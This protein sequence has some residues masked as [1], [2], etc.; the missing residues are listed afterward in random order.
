MLVVERLDAVIA[1]DINGSDVN[2]VAETA[3]PVAGGIQLA[4][5][6]ITKFE[7]TSETGQSQSDGESN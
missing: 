2:G 6:Y 4:S 3:V 5:L 7:P 1:V